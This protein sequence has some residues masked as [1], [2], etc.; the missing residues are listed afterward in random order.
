M[1][2]YLLETKA[3]ESKMTEARDAANANS[4]VLPLV[5]PVFFYF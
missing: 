3:V 5:V 2:L 1:L 4:I